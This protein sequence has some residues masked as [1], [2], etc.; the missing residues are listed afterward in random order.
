[1]LGWFLVD[2]AI[3]VA[4]WAAAATLKTEKFYDALG[5]VSFL[6][7]TAGSLFLSGTPI[8]ARKILVSAMAG[9][10][11]IRLG[12]YL[13]HRVHK[14]GKDSRFDEVKHQPLTFLVYWVMQ[15]AWVWVTLSPVLLINGSASTAPLALIDLIGVGVYA[16]GLG[17][18]V[19][20]DS[21]KDHFKSNPDNKG[22]FITEGLW[23]WSRHPNYFG[24]SLLWWGVF[25]TCASS[26]TSAPQFATVASPVFVFCLIRYLS[27]V[28]IL[29]AQAD[30]RWGHLPEYQEYKEKTPVFFPLPPTDKRTA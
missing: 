6:T 29:E 1:M 19:L 3:N 25:I 22:K 30:K 26:F 5:S 20:A 12:S 23:S 2:L 7:L 11:T 4:G 15:A 14:V 28:P 18:E 10:W 8:T 9:I 16:L 17:V 21:Q 24:E 27:G 13:I